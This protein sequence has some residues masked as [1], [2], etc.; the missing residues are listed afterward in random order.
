MPIARMM[1]VLNI[2]CSP[3][4]DYMR[5]L[6]MVTPTRAIGNERV[7]GRAFGGRSTHAGRLHPVVKPE[8]EPCG[9]CMAGGV[10]EAAKPARFGLLVVVKPCRYRSAVAPISGF[11]RMMLIVLLVWILIQGYIRAGSLLIW[12]T[13]TPLCSP[14]LMV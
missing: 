8:R 13:V 14:S 11:F 2:G 4:V 1:I 3:V 12:P 7:L 9:Y 6:Y 5:I 10:W